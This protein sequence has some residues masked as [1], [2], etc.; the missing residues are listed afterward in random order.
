[1]PLQTTLIKQPL[2]AEETHPGT[3]MLNTFL[4]IRVASGGSGDSQHKSHK[5]RHLLLHS[6]AHCNLLASGLAAVTSMI[7]LH[8][9]AT[10]GSAGLEI[11]QE[12]TTAAATAAA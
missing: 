12:A 2:H 7:E 8:H 11:S 3:E 5:Q 4:N 10:R 6:L 1:M 9:R